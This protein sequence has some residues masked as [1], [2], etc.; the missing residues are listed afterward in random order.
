MREGE[1]ERERESSE[2]RHRFMNE[3]TIS[4][5]GICVA[6]RGSVLQFVAVRHSKL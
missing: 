3:V 4:K 5:T 2:D 6:M 1:R